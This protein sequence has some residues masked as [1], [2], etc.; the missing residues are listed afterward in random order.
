VFSKVKARLP[1]PH[2]FNFNHCSVAP[3]FRI[4]FNLGSSRRQ[5]S[6]HGHRQRAD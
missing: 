3:A 6:S 5:S 2:L 4:N 1:Q